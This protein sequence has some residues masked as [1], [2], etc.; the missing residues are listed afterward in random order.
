[1]NSDSEGQAIALV[2]RVP[3]R[4]TGPVKKGQ[5]V[6]VAQNGTASVEGTGDM[7]GIA[8]EDNERHEE[9]LVECILKL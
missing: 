1:M 9:T 2:G 3:V 6:Y 7:I 4:I 5:K 8:L